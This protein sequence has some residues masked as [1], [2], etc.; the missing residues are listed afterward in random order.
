MKKLKLSLGLALTAAAV[1]AA[2]SEPVRPGLYLDQSVQAA[3]N[4]LGL[5]LGTKL[6]YRVPLV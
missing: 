2:F 1:A 5:Q 4:P 3:I 6:F